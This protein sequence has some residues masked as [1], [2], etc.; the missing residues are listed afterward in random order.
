MKETIITDN[1]MA[2]NLKER[3]YKILRKFRIK[4]LL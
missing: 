4:K 3:R 2:F 1:I